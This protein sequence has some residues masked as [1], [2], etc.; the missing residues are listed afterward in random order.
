MRKESTKPGDYKM[1]NFV[2]GQQQQK[3]RIFAHISVASS[4]FVMKERVVLVSLFFYAG[5]ERSLSLA[6][7]YSL[8]EKYVLGGKMTFV[9]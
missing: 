7:I 1:G 3:N 2:F 6:R 5:S 8:P 9:S 4:S